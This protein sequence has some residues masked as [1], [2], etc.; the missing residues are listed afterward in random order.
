MDPENGCWLKV[1]S[2]IVSSKWF[3]VVE[4]MVLLG[5]CISIFGT[6]LSSHFSTIVDKSFINKKLFL[7]V[8]DVSGRPIR[9]RL[10]P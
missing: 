9:T 3:V 8:Y 1:V 2:G 7:F 5:Y 6:P 4:G 10:R